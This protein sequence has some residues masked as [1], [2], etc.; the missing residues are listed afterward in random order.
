MAN[1][2]TQL[3]IPHAPIDMHEASYLY[4]QTFNKLIA[5]ELRGTEYAVTQGGKMNMRITLNELDAYAYGALLFF[6]EMSTAACGEFL[7]IDAFDQ[8]GVEAGKIATYALMGRE[9]YEEKAAEL[10]AQAEKD[11]AFVYS[12]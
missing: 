10:S 8:P 2:R 11:A 7:Q 1:F 5:S 4:G 9:G 6:L 3:T 12:F